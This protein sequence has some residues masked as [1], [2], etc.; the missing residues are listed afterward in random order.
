MQERNIGGPVTRGGRG[1]VARLIPRGVE[2]V[3]HVGN[4][5]GPT[6]RCYVEQL[7]C[8]VAGIRDA[9]FCECRPHLLVVRYDAGQLASITVLDRLR[10]QG[11]QARLVGAV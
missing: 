3:I 2:V 5:L 7:L 11:L 4:R 6:E 8:R 1:T 9:R 10:A